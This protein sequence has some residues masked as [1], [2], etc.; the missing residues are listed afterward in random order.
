MSDNQRR[1]VAW[2]AIVSICAVLLLVWSRVGRDS[3]WVEAGSLD[4]LKT[5]GVSYLSG[6]QVFVVSDGDSVVALLADA[7]HTDGE[8]VLYCRS[9]GWF[10]GQHG[11]QFDGLGHYMLG[12]AESGLTR[13]AVRVAEGEVEV[14]PQEVIETLP[15]GGDLRNTTPPVGPFCNGD[16]VPPTEMTP[17]FTGS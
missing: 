11:E 4:D 7:H 14:N 12:P 6:Q 1:L 2:I 5:D 16:G 15:R 10:E 13:V 8:R 3:R 9:S 17:G